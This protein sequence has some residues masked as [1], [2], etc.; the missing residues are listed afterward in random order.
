MIAL[1]S[2]IVITVVW[3]RDILINYRHLCVEGKAFNGYI[4]LSTK[5]TANTIV[6]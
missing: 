6:V 2:P 4:S 3:G 1:K 5:K